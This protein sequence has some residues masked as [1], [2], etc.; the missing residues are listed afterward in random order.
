M[1]SLFNLV[2]RNC[3]IRGYIR[4]KVCQDIVINV[5]SVSELQDNHRYLSLFTNNDKKENC[6]F[7]RLNINSIDELNKYIHSEY[8]YIVNALR[9]NDKINLDL[10]QIP[11]QYLHRLAFYVDKDCIYSGI[12]PQSLVQLIVLSWDHHDVSN[13]SL[14]MLLSNLPTSLRKLSIT[15]YYNIS[16]NTTSIQ[17]PSSLEDLDYYTGN[18][19]N[20]K[21]LVVSPTKNYINCQCVTYS[22]DDLQWIQN[23]P[24]IGNLKLVHR[25]PRP[26]TPGMIPTHIKKLYLYQNGTVQGNVFPPNL[27]RLLQ[28]PTGSIDR[29]GVSQQHHQQLTYLDV[30]NFNQQLEKDMLPLTLETLILDSY[31]SPLL[32]DVLPGRLK[33]LYLNMFNQQLDVGVLPPSLTDLKL[34]SFNQE[35]KPFVLPSQLHDL[36]L[37]VYT[38]TIVE[39]VLPPNLI[40]LI[41]YSVK[42]SLEHAPQM[43]HLS[44]LKT[45]VLDQS[46]ATMISNTNKIY[47]ATGSID[48]GF[49]IQQSSIQHLEIMM[50]SKRLPLTLNLVPNQIKTLKLSRIDI[51][52]KGLIPT[53][54]KILMTDNADLDLNLIPSTTKHTF[55]YS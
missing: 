54:C 9:I 3:Y 26:L 42:G 49:N 44:F 12:L 22:L 16:P 15:H 25:A 45:R 17:L 37:E 30:T 29:L 47:L 23:Q 18:I 55:K 7:V 40:N 2:W 41:L 53:T 20:L 14:D 21:K 24:W 38:G 10:D 5:M 39:N 28:R 51:P 32:P 36:C 50:I 46:V 8:N 4:N 19:S 34:Q 48:E 13:I 52:S 31:N 35:L 43:N 11:Q 33:E 1:D 27:I 6:I